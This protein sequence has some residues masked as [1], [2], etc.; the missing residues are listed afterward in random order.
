MAAL[1]DHPTVRSV[2]GRT[3]L[4]RADAPLDAG[5]LRDV[6][7]RAGADD[8]GFVAVDRPEV[9]DQRADVL[10]AFPR[11]RTLVAV[12]CRM[13]RE[14]V[15]GPNRAASNLE[16]HATTDHVN[17]VCR[18]VVRE[19]EA[20]GLPALNP[21]AGFPMDMTQF[22]GKV[23]AVSHK[24]VA[25]AAGLGRMGIHRNVIHPLFG[26]FVILGTILVGADV[27]EQSYPIDYN[28]CLTCKLCVAACPVG[29]IAPDGHFDFAACMTHNYREFMS[30]FTDWVETV[31]DRP[32][33]K[34]YRAKV[35]DGESA[36]LWQSLAFGPNYKAAYCLA[37]CPAGDD[38]IA[39]FL[40]DRGTFVAD[41]VKPLLQKAE[42][43]YVVPGSDAEGYVGERYPHKTPRRVGGVRPASIGGF[44]A[45]MRHVFQRGQSKG[46]DAT[47]HFTFTGREP[48]AATVVIRDGTIVVRDGLHGDP[49]CAVTADSDTWLGFLRKERSI[50]WAILRRKV[51]VKGPLRL[52]TAFGKCF[53]G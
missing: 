42:P 37:V 15:R 19:L 22:P 38:V 24:P 6:C 49:D 34:A 40:A 32:D 26:S 29:A 30:G 25:V 48:A 20:A 7:R 31:A 36:S 52:L 39:P 53:P 10:A 4:P 35:T 18:A 45:A 44:L 47:Y 12:V 2:R 23:W 5:W 51:R 46:L 14:P 27:S 43:V 1:D 16:F 17:D 11:T 13:N 41:V 8:V 33:R 28:P 9:A 50:V 3:P 21:A